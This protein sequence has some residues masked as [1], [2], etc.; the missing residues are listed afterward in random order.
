MFPFCNC[1]GIV[2]DELQQVKLVK[3]LAETSEM[4]LI[5]RTSVASSASSANPKSTA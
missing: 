5:Y 1:T 2:M 3:R 4:K